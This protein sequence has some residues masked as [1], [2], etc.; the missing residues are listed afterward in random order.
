MTWVPGNLNNKQ[1][2]IIENTLTKVFKY[3]FKISYKIQDDHYENFLIG[4]NK[5]TDLKEFRELILNNAKTILENKAWPKSVVYNDINSFIDEL[6]FD[7]NISK[8][9][10]VFSINTDNRPL[11]EWYFLTI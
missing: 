10:S 4:I 11:L 6:L 2:E 9:H 8:K 1:I 5:Q 7:Q 3:S